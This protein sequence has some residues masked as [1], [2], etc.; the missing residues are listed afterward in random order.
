MKV[1][2]KNSISPGNRRG[3]TK[4]VT[5]VDADAHGGYSFQGV[6]LSDGEHDLEEG[7]VLLAVIPVGSI[8]DGRKEARVGVVRHGSPGGVRKL[9]DVWDFG[10]DFDDLRDTV[11]AMLQQPEDVLEHVEGIKHYTVIGI[12]KGSEQ[13]WADNC[14]AKS[15]M[16]AAR[17]CIEY[18]LDSN[19][20]PR[21]RAGD[22]G[23][24]EVIEGNITT[25]CGISSEVIYGDAVFS[26]T[27]D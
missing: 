5:G 21:E 17:S 4:H 2:V 10:G 23:V 11:A 6:F 13:V 15:P 19:G 26:V 22:I 18:L 25:C 14:E 3:W 16:D 12:Y 27:E 1:Q 8:V 20:W 9:E 24:V 7:S